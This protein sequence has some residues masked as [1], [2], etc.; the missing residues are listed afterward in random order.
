MKHRT[1]FNKLWKHLPKKQITLLVGARQTGKTTLMQ[2][3]H[4]KLEKE[5]KRTFFI[6][7]ENPEIL[8]LL[9]EHP[10]NLFQIIP[11][12]NNKRKV[13]LFLDEIQ[14]LRNPTNFLKYHY[15][16][17]QDSIKFV[18]SGSS[19]FYINEKFKDSLA[20]RKRIFILP[21]L[22]FE[23]FLIFKGRGEIASFI[24]SGSIPEIYKS[25]L[26]KWLNEYLLFGGYPEVVLEE[27]LAEKKLILKEIADSY[28]KKDALE[29]N[30][31]YPDMYFKI[32]KILSAGRGLFNSN[33]IAKH[34][35]IQY[36]TINAY[37]KI[38]ER[39]FHISKILPFYRNVEKEL[40]KMPK[41]Y[42]NDLGL[43][44]YFLGNF[45]PISLRND[46]GD[47]LENFVFRRFYDFYPVDDIRFW[48][49]QKKQE[50]DFI[51]Q[52]SKAYEVKFSE[53]TFNPKKY[54]YFKKQYP[55]FYFDL[56]HL[57]NVLEFTLK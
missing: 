50:V 30:L 23:E 10:R 39:S 24:N 2:Q 48:R 34:L 26:Q 45:K 29:A 52:E 18:V 25:E 42:L 7:L 35:K 31:K 22:S 40:R 3:M 15:D 27:E 41:I 57:D 1:L 20:G 55:D 53:K 5:E 32:L 56:I 47:L 51:I 37:V 44:N 38:M 8:K 11:P 49:T 28:I 19:A 12:F 4:S 17:S 46:R 13:V 21:T 16:L 36:Q 54:S 33:N 43:R 9:D 14:Y 6:S